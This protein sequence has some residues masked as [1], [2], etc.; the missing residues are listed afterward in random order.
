MDPRA[1]EDLTKVRKNHVRGANGGGGR[2]QRE[3]DGTVHVG[4]GQARAAAERDKMKQSPV[5]ATESDSVGAS[6]AVS[7]GA[8]VVLLVPIQN[9]STL[10]RLRGS[11]ATR[12]VRNAKT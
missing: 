11:K 6:N 12:G 1:V 8:E 7:A 2:H 4:R 3:N 9:R 5:K 10:G